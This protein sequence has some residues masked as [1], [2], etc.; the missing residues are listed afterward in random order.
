MWHVWH[1]LAKLMPEAK[2]AVK[3]LGTFIRNHYP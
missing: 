3:E 1:V 2:N